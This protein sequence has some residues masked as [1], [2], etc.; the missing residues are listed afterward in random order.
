LRYTIHHNSSN[1]EEYRKLRDTSRSARRD[2]RPHDEDC[3]FSIGLF[4]LFLVSL[5]FV[6]QLVWPMY[7]IRMSDSRGKSL[8]TPGSTDVLMCTTACTVR[9]PIRGFCFLQYWSG[10]VLL[11][12]VL[13]ESAGSPLGNVASEPVT[14]ET[15]DDPNKGD[16][17][18]TIETPDNM[19]S[20]GT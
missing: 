4:F 19:G 11:P 2:S 13:G 8:T 17:P 9:L 1:H 20:P 12:S 3:E 15:P 5:L 16:C 7:T 14:I 6:V 10:E 18:V